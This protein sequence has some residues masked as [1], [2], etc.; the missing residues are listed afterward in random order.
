MTAP[1]QSGRA[2]AASTASRSDADP[3][4]A[5]GPDARVFRLSRQKRQH[6][7]LL[8]AVLAAIGGLILAVGSGTVPDAGLVGGLQLLIAAG[9]AV[10]ALVMGRDDRPQLVLDAEGLWYRDWKLPK[11][12]WDAVGDVA[13]AG[14]RVQSYL[15]IQ[16]RDPD[17]LARHAR[18]R[19]GRLVQ[20][21]ELRV[22]NG[23]LDAPLSEVQAAIRELR[24][25]A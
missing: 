11:L 18:N 19:G 15:A 3:E 22:P 20:P 2:R 17:W 10:S 7:L 9:V 4:I 1:S 14:A 13:I 6:A 8:A 24:D 23:A 21:N 5:V 12:P 25:R 16:L